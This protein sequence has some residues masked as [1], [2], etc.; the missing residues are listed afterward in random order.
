MKARSICAAFH[1]RNNTD[2]YCDIIPQINI[3][4]KCMDFRTSAS[5]RE[6]K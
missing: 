5:T 3:L 4:G 1:C 2:R 6:E